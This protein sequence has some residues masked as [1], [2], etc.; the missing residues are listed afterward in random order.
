MSESDAIKCVLHAGLCNQIF[1]IFATIAYA[2]KNKKDFVFYC[3]EKRTIDEK[4][5]VYFDSLL[6]KIEGKT[7]S[8][9]DTSLI[10]YKEPEFSYNEIPYYDKSFNLRGYYQS[11][12][13]FENYYDEILKLTGIADARNSARNEFQFLLNE[14]PCISIHFRMGD[15]WGLQANHPIM[16]PSYYN[17]ALRFLEDKI[18]FNDYTILFFCQS[19]DNHIVNKYID[20]INQQRRYVFHKVSDEIPDW[21]QLILMSLCDHHIIANSTFSWW[22]AYMSDKREK[23]ICYPSVWFGP[24]MKHIVTDD[25]CP[26]T[27][28][29]IP[30]N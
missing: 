18:D 2:I 23:I 28:N 22:G 6:Q 17:N 20:A 24:N 16:P 8:I 26:D 25:L 3:S 15:Y 30:I 4:T 19:V 12:K 29:K 7:E 9:I 11:H 1:M 5:I 13:Y 21:K 14:K 10:E 27:W